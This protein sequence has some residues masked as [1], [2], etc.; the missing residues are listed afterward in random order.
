MNEIFLPFSKP[1]VSQEAIE[2]VIACLKSGW[3]ATGPRVARFENDLKTYLSAPHVLALTSATAGLHLALTALDL[4]PGEEVIT[5]AFTFVGTFNAIV[6]AG[7]KPVL[8]DIDPHTYNIDVSLIEA[9]ITPRTRAIMPVHFAGLSVDLDVIY[10]L[11]KKYNLRVIEDAAQAIGTEYQGKKIGSFGD[12]Q[13]FSFHPNKN[14][15]TGEGGAITTRDDALAKQIS[16]L[17]FHGIDRAAFDRFSKTGS[18]H[19]DVIAPGYKYNM[20]D[21]QAALGI[22]QLPELENFIA[23]RTH[24]S[25]RYHDAFQGWAE[26]SLPKDP[27]YPHRHAWH[28]FNPLLNLDVAGM[29][30]DT[31]LQKMKDL[32]IGIGLHYDAP[33]LYRYYRETFNFKMGDFPQTENVSTRIMSL[34]LFPDM[35]EA[36]QDRVILAMRKVFNK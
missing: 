5:T 31:F 36:E 19:Y 26:W 20:T 27:A 4:Q 6:L 12:T 30:R 14:M 2:E 8:I 35:T 1:S 11:A 7:G 32:N 18:Q 21:L 33:H 17:R 13:V 23:K 16:V 15:T 10:A 34:P 28:L 25:K 3:L 24:L 29:D 22:H 9:A